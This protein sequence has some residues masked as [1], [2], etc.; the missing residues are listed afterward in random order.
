MGFSKMLRIRSKVDFGPD[1]ARCVMS[2][3]INYTL[4][5]ITREGRSWT[6]GVEDARD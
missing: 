4:R 6:R 3:C 2:R 1:A 5:V